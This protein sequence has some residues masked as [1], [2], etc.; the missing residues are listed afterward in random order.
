ITARVLFG[1]PSAR[2]RT[3]GAGPHREQAAPMDKTLARLHDVRSAQGVPARQPASERR[4]RLT[5]AAR[6]N[7]SVRPAAA[8]AARTS[9]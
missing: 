5:R 2:R 3:A 9:G 8:N 6:S 4:H 1:R 7:P